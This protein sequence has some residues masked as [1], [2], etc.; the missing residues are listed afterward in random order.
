[1][2]GKKFFDAL[3]W[4]FKDNAAELRSASTGGAPAPH[5]SVLTYLN[6]C[7]HRYRHC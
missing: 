7:R 2:L 5:W 3:I 6:D 4:S 1:M